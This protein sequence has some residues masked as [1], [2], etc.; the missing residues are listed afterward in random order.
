[1]IRVSEITGHRFGL[2]RKPP[3]VH[4][5]P[6]S[7]GIPAEFACEGVPDG[8]SGGPGTIRRGIGT[9]ISGMRTLNR[10]RQLLW[11]PLLAGLVL[12]GNTIGQ[13]AF[14]YFEYNLHMQLDWIVWQFFI[15]LVTM[16]CL[17]FLLAGLFLSI[18]S[19]QEGSTSF[20]E[21]LAGAKKYKKAICLWSF[22]LALA[23]ML[24]VIVFSY[25]PAWFPTPEI[26]FLYH[27]GFGRF[28]SF[29]FNTLSQFPFNLS[30][31]PPT[32]LFTEIPGYGGRSMLLW[33]YPG[34]RETLVFSAINLLLFVLTPFVVP[35]I[36]L[37]QK[38]PGEA[39]AE[40]FAVIKKTGGVAAVSAA[41]LGGIVYGV[42]LT[43]LLVQAA[44]GM[45]T[46]LATYYRLTD[47]WFVLGL[48][49]D[50]ALLIVAL[51]A[52]TIGGIA[53]LD[54]YIPAKTGQ[55]PESAERETIA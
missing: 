47:T 1:M 40:S 26:L 41:F 35:L 39:V 37:G 33:F 19:G 3:A 54:L 24:L 53:M 27:Q 34:F 14:W 50:L 23:G 15:E 29:L 52:A 48:V 25:V 11:F 21:G 13:A 2:C 16:V 44:H 5:L 9:V 18:P 38:A 10:N 42:F 28:D 6:V 46:P 45:V 20:F 43:Y 4:V 32:D 49:Y 55:M 30:R 22:V 31:L 8:G 12:A 17:V 51:V 7:I 36:V